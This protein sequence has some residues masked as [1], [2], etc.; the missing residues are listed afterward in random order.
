MIDIIVFHVFIVTNL[1]PSHHQ[2]GYKS[3]LRNSKSISDL[4]NIPEK[5]TSYLSGNQ[6]NS[7]VYDDY[8]FQLPVPSATHIPLTGTGSIPELLTSSMP[9]TVPGVTGSVPELV[10]SCLPQF[11]TGSIP[12]LG[13]S[14]LSEFGNS[15]ADTGAT[16]IGKIGAAMFDGSA[17]PR[18]QQQ[19]GKQLLEQLERDLLEFDLLMG[20]PPSP[21]E[22]DTDSLEETL[23]SLAL[24]SS[25]E[26]LF[27]PVHQTRLRSDEDSDSDT[28]KSE[29]SNFSCDSLED[30]ENEEEEEPVAEQ[31]AKSTPRFCEIPRTLPL[32]RRKRQR[33][34][35]LSLGGVTRKRPNDY[36]S[37]VFPTNEISNSHSQ[38]FRTA[39][40][41]ALA[42]SDSSHSDVQTP[43]N[44]P[45]FSVKFPGH[46]S[47][48]RCLTA[49]DNSHS[50]MNQQERE[51]LQGNDDNTVSTMTAETHSY[52][53]E[54]STPV[55]FSIPQSPAVEQLRRQGSET[56]Q[57]QQP[58]KSR[59]ILP[60]ASVVAAEDFPVVQA[61]PLPPGPPPAVY[62][63][64]SQPLIPQGVI[65]APGRAHRVLLAKKVTIQ[66]VLPSKRKGWISCCTWLLSWHEE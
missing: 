30:G 18:D 28:V 6:G 4:S 59:V 5:D 26:R 46:T 24:L 48:S 50:Y 25:Q 11:V 49:S 9:T 21:P 8:P 51:D 16:N 64:S 45:Y 27:K 3:N 17:V 36:E 58:H 31:E 66:Q 60:P 41:T 65:P 56:S 14:C 34:Q 19:T 62:L 7:H 1:Y 54:R 42:N 13:S 39:S 37:D 43:T 52:H 29:T 15:G 61:Q 38:V 33:W 53:L 23:R 2:I 32:P 12:E 22:V 10:S 63:P 40:D 47:N 20:C 57:R 35:R 44:P 55:S